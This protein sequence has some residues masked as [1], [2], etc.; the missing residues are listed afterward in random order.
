VSARLRYRND[1][2]LALYARTKPLCALPGCS[3][4]DIGR[5]V[6]AGQ[7]GEVIAATL[8]VGPMSAGTKKSAQCQLE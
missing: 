6:S 2:I 8:P 4:A 7:P 1:T 5:T 3:L